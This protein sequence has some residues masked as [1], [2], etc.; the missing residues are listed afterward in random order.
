MIVGDGDA[1]AVLVAQRLSA[2]GDDVDEVFYL[3]DVAGGLICRLMGV[4]CDLTAADYGDLDL[5]HMNIP[6]LQVKYLHQL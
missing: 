6:P 2:L 1:A 4:V 5:F 3:G